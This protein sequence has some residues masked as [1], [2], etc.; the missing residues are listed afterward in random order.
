MKVNYQI[1][2]HFEPNGGFQTVGGNG[3]FE[4]TDDF[5]RRHWRWWST[6]SLSLG[7]HAFGHL[8]WGTL[9]GKV[10]I[11]LPGTEKGLA[12]HWFFLDILKTEKTGK[13]HTQINKRIN[14][15]A[16]ASLITREKVV[17]WAGLVFTYPVRLVIYL[18]F[19]VLSKVIIQN[20]RIMM[21]SARLRLQRLMLCSIDPFSEIIKTPLA[22]EKAQYLRCTRSGSGP[23]WLWKV[24]ITDMKYQKTRA[25]WPL[26]SE[27]WGQQKQTVCRSPSALL[28]H[29][30]AVGLNLT[31][32]LTMGQVL[33]N[34][35]KRFRRH[36]SFNYL[37]IRKKILT[38]S[39]YYIDRVFGSSTLTQTCLPRSWLESQH[40]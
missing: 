20:T 38:E 19:T 22:A 13:D 17:E 10:Q 39:L 40:W 21:I 24:V 18:L 1:V 31:T 3:A 25:V 12:S 34:P 4:E 15:L 16:Y 26:V 7:I 32:S 35:D 33:R 6:R 8:L 30:N 29:K 9:D 11:D 14:M 27:R 37:S 2:G 36:R 28:Q 5:K 23:L